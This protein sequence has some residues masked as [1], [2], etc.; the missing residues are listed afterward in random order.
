MGQTYLTLAAALASGRL[1]AFID[2][3][4][5]RGIPAADAAQFEARLE[6]AIN[7]PPPAAPPPPSPSSRH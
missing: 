6:T 4:L 1:D 5:T 3:E 2:Q 7:Q